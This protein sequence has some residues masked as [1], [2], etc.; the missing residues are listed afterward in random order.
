MD[1][2][3]GMDGIHTYIHTYIYVNSSNNSKSKQ[4]LGAHATPCALDT[5]TIV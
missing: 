3:G 4:K 5:K 2:I 1:A